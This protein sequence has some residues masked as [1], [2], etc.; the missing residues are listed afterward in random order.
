MPTDSLTTVLQV[1][2]PRLPDGRDRGVIRTFLYRPAGGR[3]ERV[4][5]GD[6]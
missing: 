2:A 5:E 1:S 6:V 4:G 3:R